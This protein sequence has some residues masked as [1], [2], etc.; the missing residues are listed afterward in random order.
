MRHGS[1]ILNLESSARVSN[2]HNDEAVCKIQTRIVTEAPEQNWFL[3]EW[4][5]HFNKRQSALTNDLGW[6]KGRANHIWHGKQPYNRMIVNEVSAWLG[7]E[8]YE[9]LMPPKRALQ[10]RRFE[11]TAREIA[12]S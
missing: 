2:P 7:I 10:L 4:M 3:Q 8:P 9:L 11:E 12:T 5:A 6:N 1:D